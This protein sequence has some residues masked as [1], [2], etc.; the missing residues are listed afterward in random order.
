MPSP[1]V[2]LILL[3]KLDKHMLEVLNSA[4]NTIQ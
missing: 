4:T 2:S 3:W 1:M